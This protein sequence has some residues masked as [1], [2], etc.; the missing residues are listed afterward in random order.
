[1]LELQAILQPHFL[2]I[3]KL[4]SRHGLLFPC[5]YVLFTNMHWLQKYSVKKQICLK[6]FL[7]NKYIHEFVLFCYYGHQKRKQE[8]IKTIAEY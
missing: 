1:M 2:V 8:R 5:A 3:E 4:K 6:S 7:K